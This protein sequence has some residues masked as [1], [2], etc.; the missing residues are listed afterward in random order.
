MKKVYTNPEMT[1]TS[2]EAK[3]E[4]MALN[5]SSVQ[6]SIKSNDFSLINFN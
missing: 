5:S 3:S 1:F 6:T 2:Y 4:I